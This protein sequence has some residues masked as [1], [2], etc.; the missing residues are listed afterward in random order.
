MDKLILTFSDP[1]GTKSRYGNLIY[2]NGIF[3]TLSKNLTRDSIFKSLKNRRT[4][5]TTGEREILLLRANGN[6]RA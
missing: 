2:K 5:A 1:E 3:A 4:F 6:T